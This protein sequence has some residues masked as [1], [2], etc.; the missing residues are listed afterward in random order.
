[1][2]QES[3]NKRVLCFFASL[4]VVI[5]PSGLGGCCDG[6]RACA[7]WTE[8]VLRGYTGSTVLCITGLADIQG[9]ALQIVVHSPLVTTVGL[10]SKLTKPTQ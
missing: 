6:R 8:E 9:Q 1:M 4:R 5:S 7:K 2:L 10:K 3:A